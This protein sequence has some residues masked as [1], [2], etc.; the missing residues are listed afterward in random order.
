MPAD[1]TETTATEEQERQVRLR[2]LVSA[3]VVRRWAAQAGVIVPDGPLDDATVALYL[4]WRGQR[5]NARP[6]TGV[7]HARPAARV[8]GAAPPVS[9]A[10]L[11]A[12]S[13]ASDPE[14]CPT[15]GGPGYLTYVDLSRA[16][17]R[18]RCPPCGQQWTSAIAPV[19]LD[20]DGPTQG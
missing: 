20:V 9:P 8:P 10:L 3:D 4:Y 17:Q 7:R 19:G 6:Y 18:Q 5:R 11:Q 2:P 13:C 1:L 16:V 12:A 14:P 15:C